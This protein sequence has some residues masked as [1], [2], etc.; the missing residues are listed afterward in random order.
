MKFNRRI[1]SLLEQIRHKASTSLPAPTLRTKDEHVKRRT[2][3]VLLPVRPGPQEEL[4]CGDSQRKY[5]DSLFGTSSAFG[6]LRDLLQ[7]RPFTIPETLRTATKWNCHIV[8][9]MR[10]PWNGEIAKTLAEGLFQLFNRSANAF[11]PVLESSTLDRILNGFFDFSRSKQSTDAELFY[12]VVAI[13]SSV[14]TKSDPSLVVWADS[15]FAKAIEVLHTDCDHSSRASNVLLFERTLLICIYLLLN[16][17]AG[18]IW[19]HLG[20]AIRHYLDLSHRPS[21]EELDEGHDWFCTLTRTLYC[22]ERYAT[23]FS[24][25]HLIRHLMLP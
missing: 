17:Q 11:F 14:G 2:M 13:A 9:P 8:S 23:K 16:P 6:C 25:L 20:F 24:S 5:G 19:R 18:D 12:L 4:L 1:H 15:S 7:K 10:L 21:T 22:L 3:G